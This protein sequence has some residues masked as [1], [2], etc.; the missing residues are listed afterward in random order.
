MKTRVSNEQTISP[1]PQ[2]AAQ[3][4]QPRQNITPEKAQ[5]ILAQHGL[6]TS[7][8]QAKSVVEFLYTLA[9]LTTR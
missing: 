9:K 4:Q 7:L 2:V 3:S 6:Q 8:S 5:Q 1:S